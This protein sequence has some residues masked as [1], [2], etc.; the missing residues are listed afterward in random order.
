MKLNKE[1]KVV[2]INLLDANPWNPNE[3]AL[4]MFDKVR[5]NIK[6]YGF[7]DPV[8][9]R[10]KNER[11]QIIDG[12]HRWRAAKELGFTEVTIQNM[13]E[14]HDWDAEFLTLQ[15]NNLR[16]E[17]NQVKRGK[18]LKDLQEQKPELLQ[19]LPLY[20]DQIQAEIGALNF[21]PSYSSE[22]PNLLEGST[23]LT[24]RV[25]NEDIDLVL[26]VLAS[27]DTNKDAAFLKLMKE[28]QHLRG[29]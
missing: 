18:I 7:I 29:L 3:E 28:E 1:L 9:V 17:D 20:D 12:E 19:F 23:G 22:K 13:G 14:V 24:F 21:T 5:S 26:K 10:E 6:E 11:Y 27:I 16:G 2:D 4:E 15:M 25:P 8:L